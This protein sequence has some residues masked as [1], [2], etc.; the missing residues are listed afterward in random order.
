MEPG[1]LT[2]VLVG[3]ALGLVLGLLGG[4]GGMLAVPLF[5]YVLDQP[6][7]TATTMSL[8]VVA[9]GAAGGLV[10][11]TRAGRVDWR[12]GIGFGLL[13]AVGAI[14]G[15]RVSVAVPERLLLGG[16]VVLLLVAAW[17]M[18]RPA[19]AVD[20]EESARARATWPTVL[21]VAT[22]VGFTTGFFGVG[23][24][25]VVVP[26]LVVALRL[27]VRRATATG[28]VVIIVNSATALLARADT[29]LD[30]RLTVELSL[31][32]ALA[33]VG[34]AML[35]PKVP[36]GLLRRA[37]GVLVLFAA[38]YTAWETARA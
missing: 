29:G 2:V 24:G 31:A 27:P 15:S 34:G 22:A 25:F 13:G 17:S 7:D 8:L 9:V 37:F 1:L 12:L 19:R 36:A 6:V 3:A 10:Q 26:A 18:L 21:A 28:L 33:A 23:G 5:V 35:S 16:F 32:A 38:V 30:A 4:G 14:A 20:E 11:H